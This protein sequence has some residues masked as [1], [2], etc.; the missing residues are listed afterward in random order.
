MATWATLEAE[1]PDLA[2]AGKQLI[3]QF[4]VGL[5]FLATVRKDGGPR[6]HP[7]CPIITAGGLY[8]FLISSPKCQDLRRDGRYALHSYPPEQV[9]DEFYVTGH[10]TEITDPAIREAVKAAYHTT[11]EDDHILFALDIDRCLH[12]KYQHRGDWPP[13]YTKWPAAPS[14]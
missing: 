12:A 6:L 13:T 11:V 14:P 10:A 8:T 7:I 5:G 9:D 4:G 2:A 1:A 3:Y